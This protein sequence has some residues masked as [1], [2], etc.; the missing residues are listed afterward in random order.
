[1]HA[2]LCLPVSFDDPKHCKATLREYKAQLAADRAVK[3]S[4]GTN[5][6]SLNIKSGKIS[7]KQHKSKDKEAHK[8]DKSSKRQKENKHSKKKHKSR[9]KHH[10]SRQKHGSSSSSSFSGDD[11]AAALPEKASGPVPLSKFMQEQ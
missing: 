8:S 5:Q 11:E 9:D 3:L 10:K 4:G 1:M 6:P 7:K 2:R